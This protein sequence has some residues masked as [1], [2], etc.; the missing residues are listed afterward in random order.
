MEGE[1]S[2]NSS[3]E[4]NKI[5]KLPVLESVQEITLWQEVR[6]FSPLWSLGVYQMQ[7]YSHNYQCSK[8]HTHLKLPH[9]SGIR[10]HRQKPSFVNC[11]LNEALGLGVCHLT[12]S[13][14]LAT[15]IKK[16]TSCL[17]LSSLRGSF[18]FPG[19]LSAV[20]LMNSTVD[21]Q[22]FGSLLLLPMKKLQGLYGW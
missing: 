5:N 3:T 1:G 4:K 16:Y 21:R 6:I 14:S 2:A 8:L 13:S 9:Q 15:L 17:Q 19:V 20:R 22:Y 10:S 18:P 11:L 7:P 12:G